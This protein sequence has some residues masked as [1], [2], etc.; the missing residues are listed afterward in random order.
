MTSFKSWTD[1]K[2]FYIGIGG[3]VLGAAT[4][5]KILTAMGGGVVM[6]APF[7]EPPLNIAVEVIEE[8]EDPVIDIVKL[9]GKALEAFTGTI[10]LATDVIGGAGD[11]VDDVIETGG[12]IIEDIGDFFGF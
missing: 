5:T 12:D 1:T 3:M 6:A 8:I 10:S 2:V 4:N 7:I 11:V 9:V